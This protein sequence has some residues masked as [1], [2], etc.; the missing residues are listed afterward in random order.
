LLLIIKDMDQQNMNPQH[1]ILIS[2]D[3]SESS[4]NAFTMAKDGL[5]KAGDSLKVAH[6]SNST[7]TYLPAHL[8]PEAIEARFVGELAAIDNSDYVSEDLGLERTTKE[9]MM[10]MA[11][12]HQASLMV[13]GWQGRK[14]PKEDPTLMGSAVQYIGIEAACPVA[15]IKVN[16]PRSTRENGAFRFAV[17]YDGHLSSL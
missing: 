6:I 14:G 17:C 3:G 4:Y 13:V 2:V 1:N 16:K 8:K 12:D 10:D 11:R 15:I 7:K 9:A 5:M